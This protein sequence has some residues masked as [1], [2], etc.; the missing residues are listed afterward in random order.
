VYYPFFSVTKNNKRTL[1][2]NPLVLKDGQYEMDFEDLEAKL[3]TSVQLMIFCNP[4]NPGGRV[5]SRADVARVS[6]LCRQYGTILVSDEIHS[7]LLFPGYTHYPA[8]ALSKEDAAN[9]VTCFAP[10]KTF[11]VAGLAASYVVIPD[12]KLRAAYKRAMTSIGGDMSNIFGEIGLE[13][14]YT[15]GEPWLQALMAYLADNLITV[16]D[17][18][19]KHLPQALVVAPQGTYLVWLDFRALGVTQ[20]ALME[21]MTHRGGV[22]LSNGAVFGE[23]G[24]G[25]L[26]LNIACPKVRLAEGLGCPRGLIGYARQ[27]RHVQHA[28]VVASDLKVSLHGAGPATRPPAIAR[29]RLPPR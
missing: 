24:E 18:F 17:F 16:Q 3:K 8:A 29:P 12:T 11:N 1:V 5:W 27:R 21:A 28:P 9:T 13:A 14:A 7:D 19:A 23:G 26:R 4:H 15:C 25:F 20:E 10:S 6:A 2:N 22:G